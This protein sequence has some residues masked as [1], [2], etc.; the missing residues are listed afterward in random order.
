[1]RFCPFCAQENPDDARECGHCGKRLPPPR[2]APP[3]P[4]HA[5]PPVAERPKREIPARPAPRS[6]PLKGSEPLPDRPHDP[7][8]HPIESPA[9]TAPAALPSMPGA[10]PLKPLGQLDTQAPTMSGDQKLPPL[11]PPPPP[12]PGNR[13]VLGIGALDPPTTPHVKVPPS[14]PRPSTEPGLPPVQPFPH[15]QDS[16]RRSTK[17]LSVQAAASAAK[18]QEKQKSTGP[19]GVNA[20]GPT[21]T[22]PSKAAPRS[23]PRSHFDD[24]QSTTVDPRAPHNP[25]PPAIV[26]THP[27]PKLPPPPSAELGG[28]T[29]ENAPNQLMEGGHTPVLPT[30]ALPPMPPPPRSGKI[31]DSVMYLLP[32]AKAI[33]A[34]KKAQDNI[35]A[36]LHGDQ[37]L[38]DQV[39]RDL[40]RAA[41]EAKLDVPAV[42]EEMRRVRAEEDRR[43]KAEQSL[44]EVDQ[45]REKELQRWG[46]EEAERTQD[47]DER[48]GQIRGAEEELRKKG[49]ERRI[50]DAE[51]AKI[52]AQIR[53]LEKKAAQEDAR[54]AK[55]DVTPPEKGGGPNTAANARNAADTARKEATGLIPSRDIARAKV[56][57]LDAPIAA[58]TKQVVDGRATLGLKRKE[59][60]E[61]QA[62]HKRQLAQFDADKRRA[63]AERDGAEREMSQRFTAAGTLLNLNRVQDSRFQ[64][65]YDRIDELK[66]GVNAREAAIVRLEGERRGYDRPSVQKGLLAIGI[67]AGAVILL[68]IIL[69]IV[70]GRH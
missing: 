9:D 67:G 32:V 46:A 8:P 37:K 50:H 47:A 55:A 49:D 53:A 23:Q 40:G 11:T 69:I 43:G 6:M 68:M 33:W 39:L 5:A 1:M 26:E 12:K 45:N 35:R 44:I 58:L 60:T 7:V 41:R 18:E 54:A 59:L 30:L 16:E 62:A 66:A 52:D 24:E 20:H 29:D 3:R 31:V 65:L 64:S 38:L 15:D 2:T 10:R 14:N 48:E 61:S 25:L 27:V 42:A 28:D 4:A 21:L 57:A 63:E 13:T 19:R 36:L 34:R 51:R 22:A 56:D 17:P 70:L